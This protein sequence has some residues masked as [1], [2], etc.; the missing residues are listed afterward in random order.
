MPT[1]S[2]RDNAS[3]FERPLTAEVSAYLL[4]HHV[5]SDAYETSRDPFNR[6][7]RR[8]LSISSIQDLLLSSKPVVLDLDLATRD[9]QLPL[10]FQARTISFDIRRPTSQEWILDTLEKAF[11]HEPTP[12]PCIVDSSSHASVIS[13]ASS[14]VRRSR[15]MSVDSTSASFW[16]EDSLEVHVRRKRREAHQ[17]IS[18]PA[19]L[20]RA[21]LATESPRRPQ[22]WGRDSIDIV[23]ERQ[24]KATRA[25]PKDS[26]DITRERKMLAERV[27]LEAPAVIVDPPPHAVPVRKPDVRSI[28]PGDGQT[29]QADPAC[30][31]SEADRIDQPVDI[32]EDQPIAGSS[33]QTVGRKDTIGR[34]AAR[35]IKALFTANA[36]AMPTAVSTMTI[37]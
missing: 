35:K 12:H 24:Q 27:E 22:L 34:K 20:I 26:I 14:G 5:S 37:D 8:S 33:K 36:P 19:P 28:F 15:S 16:H 30:S 21:V 31:G 25:W 10:A 9:G 3:L 13:F 23:R 11:N 17:R 32:D 2:L 4:G 18:G 1:P 6:P 29:G 7:L